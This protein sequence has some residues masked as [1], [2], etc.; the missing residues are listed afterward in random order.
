MSGD[1][2]QTSLIISVDAGKDALAEDVD[3]LARQLRNE[4][5]EFGVES[6]SLHTAAHGAPHGTKSVEAVTLG[7]LAVTILPTALP[8]LI[9]FLQAWSLR[10]KDR[11]VKIK[12]TVGDRSV[13]V[14]YPAG[15]SETVV[16]ELIQKMTDS[17]T[18]GATGKSDSAP[19]A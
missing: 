16:K 2:N 13:D 10:S 3:A 14:E 1:S 11:T 9:E 19:K 5:Q 18:P 4:I 17:L 6:V 8:R 12:A 7:A 15:T